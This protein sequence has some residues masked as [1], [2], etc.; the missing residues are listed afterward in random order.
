VPVDSASRTDF[1]LSDCSGDSVADAEGTTSKTTAEA[2]ADS[3]CTAEA[4]CPRNSGDYCLQAEAH[5][6]CACDPPSPCA[7]S[8]S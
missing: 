4:G 2:G 6:S 7:S 5:R 8:L 1:L 3:A